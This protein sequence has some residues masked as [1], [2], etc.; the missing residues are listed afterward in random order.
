MWGR[1]KRVV[2][3]RPVDVSVKR[4]SG[5]RLQERGDVIV[6]WLV[7]LQGISPQAGVS[8]GESQMPLYDLF[9]LVTPSSCLG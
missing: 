5:C 2:Y 7:N 3:G 6:E 1:S 8:S 4:R 9:I